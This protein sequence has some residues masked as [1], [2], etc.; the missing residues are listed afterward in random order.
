MSDWSGG[1]VTSVEYVTACIP[2]QGPIHLD[3]VALLSCVEPPQPRAGRPIASWAP[4]K[5]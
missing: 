5:A 3:L 4:A 1:Y 2:E